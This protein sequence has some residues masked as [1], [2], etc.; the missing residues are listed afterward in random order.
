MQHVTKIQMCLCGVVLYDE[1]NQKQVFK[2][3]EDEDVVFEDQVVSV[4]ADLQSKPDSLDGIPKQWGSHIVM[5]LL[6]K[7]ASLFA[8]RVSL[9]VLGAYFWQPIFHDNSS[10]DDDSVFIL[11]EEQEFGDEDY[12]MGLCHPWWIVFFTGFTCSL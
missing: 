1:M 11:F 6:L 7:S 4:E 3:M 10:G 8:S 5:H 9:C 2:S 12:S